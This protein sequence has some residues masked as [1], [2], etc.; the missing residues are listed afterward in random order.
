MTTPPEPC[1]PHPPRWLHLLALFTVCATLPLLLLGAEVTTKQV[2]MVDDVGLR[3]PW[4]LFTMFDRATREV[5]FLIEHSHRTVGW[6]VGLCVIGLAVG[7]W[8]GVRYRGLRWLGVAAVLAV[9]VQGILGK[10]RVDLNAVM[11]KELA[12][13]HGLFAQLVFALLV[14]L[15]LFTSR[16]WAA[17]TADIPRAVRRWSLFTALLIYTQIVL[18]ALVRHKDTL[19]GA[20][21]HLLVAFAVVAAVLWLARLVY[22]HAAHEKLLTRSAGVLVALVAV[23]LVLG[24]ESWL[25]RFGAPQWRQLQPLFDPNFVRTLHFLTGSF[26]FATSVVAALSAHRGLA[27]GPRTAGWPGQSLRC[28]GAACETGASQTQPRPPA[29]AP[30][31]RLEGA[32]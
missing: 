10:Q 25:G 31:G 26:L 13:V 21:L 15:A 16:A 30:V 6:V 5:G 17:A 14:S 23:Q 3:T 29:Q 9:G 2:G 18:G 4:H 12:L 28:P 27:W 24:V 22:E 19:L 8:R 1:C 7:M 32:A 11:G 20:R